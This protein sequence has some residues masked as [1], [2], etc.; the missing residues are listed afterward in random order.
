VTGDGRRAGSRYGAILEHVSLPEA[1]TRALRHRI[2][3]NELPAESR[4]VEANLAAE[5]GVS[6]GTIRDAM[7]SLQAEGLID[8]VPR[9]Y[10]VVTRMSTEDAEDVCFARY[11]LEDASLENGFGN[12]RKDLLKALRLALEHMSV[13]AR[14]NDMDALVESDTQF[15]EVLI[16]VSGRSRLKDLWSM[17]NSQMGALMRAELERQ[18]IEMTET[19][20]RH[21]A[22]VE[23]VTDGDLDRL[24]AELRIHYL[25][26]F[27]EHDG[28]P[29]GDGRAPA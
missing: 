8:I 17:L 9:R 19:V 23:A 2:L 10:S 6:R 25:S 20:K 18:G 29:A 21:L 28:S 5:F 24:R 12:R 22:I 26:G 1:V 14:L 4:L 16:D 7:R 11:V 13:A 15:H 3:N 27:P